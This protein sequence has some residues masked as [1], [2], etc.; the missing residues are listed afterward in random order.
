MMNRQIVIDLIGSLIVH[1]A[2]N[3]RWIIANSGR[4]CVKS[5]WSIAA[6]P[7]RSQLPNGIASYLQ[8]VGIAIQADLAARIDMLHQDIIPVIDPTGSYLCLPEHRL[9]MLSHGRK[10]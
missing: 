2:Q 8:G 3:S 9:S 10:R 6:V 1:I 4:G 5:A 7:G